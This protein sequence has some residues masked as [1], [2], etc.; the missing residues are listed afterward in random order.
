[1]R[2]DLSGS[3]GWRVALGRRARVLRQETGLTLKV[4][5]QRSGLSTRFLSQVEAGQANPS[6][7]SLRDLA[8]G[9]EQSLADLLE[10]RRSESHRALHRMIEH[11]PAQACERIRDMVQKELRSTPKK[12]ALLGL[13]G[14]GKSSAGPK[15]A[16]LLGATFVEVDKQIEQEAGMELGALFQLHGERYYRDLERQILQTLLRDDAPL[17]LAPGG[18]VVTHPES[19]ALLRDEAATI[20][21][22]AS[23]QAHWDRVLSQGDLRPMANRSRARAELEIL[24]EARALSYETSDYVVDTGDFGIEEVAQNIHDQIQHRQS[25]HSDPGEDSSFDPTEKTPGMFS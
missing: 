12:V 24:Y 13:R 20:W 4:L 14:A 25:Q 22:K 1:M 19:W 5:S 8:E 15:L 2:G 10:E 17:V 23:P 16:T 3:N 18:G 9:L 6:L 21:L 11:L 7:G